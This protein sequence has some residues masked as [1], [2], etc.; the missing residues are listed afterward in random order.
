MFRSKTDNSF[1]Y[2]CYEIT[3]TLVPRNCIAG[4]VVPL[5][6]GDYPRLR[7]Y[8]YFDSFI[9]VPGIADRRGCRHITNERYAART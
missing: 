7:Y 4:T 1:Y 2:V 9:T 3:C 6:K 8:R 5:L